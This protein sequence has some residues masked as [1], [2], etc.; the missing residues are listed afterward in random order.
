MRMIQFP[1]D[2][3]IHTD[4]LYTIGKNGHGSIIHSLTTDNY[5]KI[6]TSLL[7]WIP[8]TSFGVS[9]ITLAATR[10]PRHEARYTVP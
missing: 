6:S 4:I 5:L 1:I 9:E 10:E 8:L 7:I 2:S 3:V